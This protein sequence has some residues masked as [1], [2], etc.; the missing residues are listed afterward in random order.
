MPN[1]C[2]SSLNAAHKWFFRNITWV[3]AVFF[4]I[5]LWLRAPE[6]C[7]DTV[8][9]TMS[10]IGFGGGPTTIQPYLCYPLAHT[11]AALSS[12]APLFAYLPLYLTL[13]CFATTI[14]LARYLVESRDGSIGLRNWGG[15]FLLIMHITITSHVMRYHHVGYAAAAAGLIMMLQASPKRWFIRYG[16]GLILFTAGI[17]LRADSL[18][19]VMLLLAAILFTT[20]LQR[21]ARLLGLLAVPCLICAT[22]YCTQH[23]F[24]NG[25][26]WEAAEDTP[27]QNFVDVN[28]ARMSLSDYED[29]GDA[30]KEGD[31][32]ALGFTRNDKAMFGEFLYLHRNRSLPGWMEQL[33]AIRR[34]GNATLTL[35]PEALG[36]RIAKA[37]HNPHF[38]FHYFLAFVA[39]QIAFALFPLPRT[40]RDGRIWI[41][42]AAMAAFAIVILMGRMNMSSTLVTYYLFLPLTCFYTPRATG[43]APRRS[44]VSLFLLC[45]GAAASAIF[46][47]LDYSLL[48]IPTYRAKLRQAI[49]DICP[50]DPEVL[51]VCY[52][53]TPIYFPTYS[54][55]KENYV[56]PR[57][58]TCMP[59]YT[60]MWP[61]YQDTFKRFGIPSDRHLF[62]SPNVKF[63]CH[64][65]SL[66]CFNLIRT[67]EKEQHGLELTQEVEQKLPSGYYIVK[68]TASPAAGMP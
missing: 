11:L 51:Y 6:M 59:G 12:H 42:S 43:C 38:K 32:L 13:L 2:L 35:D 60:S 23:A 63:I 46:L 7:V 9:H 54:I 37:I 45:A 61:C 26:M 49:D 47:T 58:I 15:L 36:I 55:W 57:N 33:D 44:L 68:L 53:V 40:W 19:V 62:H 22:A 28:H 21:Q 3:A 17:M 1:D 4:P 31:Y 39:L 27:V 66:P 50:K 18:P 30:A 56:A 41:S 65:P 16:L 24:A 25:R 64:S 5:S 52:S 20:L 34:E 67:Y 10:L 8:F 29:P 48:R 14:A